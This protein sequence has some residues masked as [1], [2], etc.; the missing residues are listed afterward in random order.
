MQRIWQYTSTQ[1]A[2]MIEMLRGLVEIE[3]PS[4]EPEA[5]N[6]LGEFLAEQ[7]TQLGLSVERIPTTDDADVVLARYGEGESPIMIL[8]HLDT[9]WPL[10]TLAHR[11]IRIEGNRLYGP[12]S[13]DMKGGLA[14]A[15]HAMEALLKLKLSPRRPITFFL[16][17]FEEVGGKAYRDRLEAEARRSHSVLVLEP[18]MPGGAAKTARKGAGRLT[19]RVRG[20]AAHAGLAPD[21]GVSAITELAHQVLRLTE[22]NDSERGISV[23][24]GVIRGGQRANVVADE[25]EAELDIRFTTLRDGEALVAAINQLEPV[26]SGA[27]LEVIGG[28]SAP[29]LERTEAVVALYQRA[30][31][32]ALEL[33][34]D[35][36]EASAGGASEGCYTA[37]VGVPTLDGLGPDGDGAHASHEHVLIPSLPL[38]TALL[39]GLLLKL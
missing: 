31:Q 29:P 35:L 24:V 23:N 20:R 12:G 16:T 39:A 14:V 22:L 36:P 11:P 1:T 37:A 30:R 9:V 7:Y 8:G 6:R 4:T 19:L 17:P 38:R 18:P 2:Q 10:G 15:L 27:K 34:F 33:G 32:I 5:I 26:L 28:I 25:A 13:F 3:S 21:E